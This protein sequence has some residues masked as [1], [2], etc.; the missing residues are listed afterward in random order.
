MVECHYCRRHIRLGSF[1]FGLD[2]VGSRCAVGFR[3]GLVIQWSLAS[4]V[5]SRTSVRDGTQSPVVKLLFCDSSVS[6]CIAPDE[7][8][9]Y[10]VFP[11][12]NL[13]D[14]H[15]PRLQYL[16]IPTLALAWDSPILT[17]LNSLWILAWDG[18]KN[19]YGGSIP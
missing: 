7:Q 18:E 11:I 6:F 14:N 13:F 4:G 12:T 9:Q 17:N 8:D 1:D 19:T 10:E 16:Q 2:E 15:A 5:R 3:D